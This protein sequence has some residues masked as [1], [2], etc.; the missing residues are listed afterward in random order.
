M[1]A[2]F[3]LYKMKIIAVLVLIC[4]S[5]NYAGLIPE[6]WSK[7]MMLLCTVLTALGYAVGKPMGVTNATIPVVTAKVAK[8]DAAKVA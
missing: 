3:T 1:P 2:W 7:E 6:E 4:G 5:S 8:T